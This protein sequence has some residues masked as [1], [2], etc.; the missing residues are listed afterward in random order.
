MN[1][2]PTAYCSLESSEHL[3]LITVIRDSI[4][5]DKDAAVAPALSA[6]QKQELQRRLSAHKPTRSTAFR[7]QKL[8]RFWRLK[9]AML[10]SGV[11]SDLKKRRILLVDHRNDHN[12]QKRI[13]H[14]RFYP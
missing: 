12:Q 7:V 5:G 11:W 14:D 9:R 3:K 1:N 13:R 10:I 4:A 6:K 8:T 2:I